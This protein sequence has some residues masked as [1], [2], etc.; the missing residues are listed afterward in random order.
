M[1]AQNF[2][3]V[4]QLG[5]LQVEVLPKIEAQDY[6]VRRNLLEMVS[7]T[8]GLQLHGGVLGQL[9]KNDSSILD[10]LIRRYCDL[11]WEALHKGVIRRYESRQ[12]NLSVLR[13]R[14]NISQQLRHNAV[15][16][17]RLH[18]TFDEFTQDTELNRVLKL[19]LRIL[20][21]TAKSASS[22]RSLSE[23]LFCFDEVADVSPDMV[24]W[25]RVVFDRLSARYQPLIRMAKLFIDGHSPDLTAGRSDGFAVLFDM[26][27][28]FEEYVG[29]Q[30]QRLTAK[31]GIRTMLQQPVMNLA[32]RENGAPCFQMRPDIVVMD[33]V[34]P[35]VV[36]DTKWKRLQPGV[37]KEAVSSQDIYQLY[38]YSQRYKSKH[39]YMVY[40]HHPELGNW[41]PTRSR[42]QFEGEVTGHSD[43]F[44]HITTVKLDDLKT[45]PQQLQAI[46]EQSMVLLNSGGV[47]QVGLLV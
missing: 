27:E 39:V 7:Q 34:N 3:G 32:R 11:L 26:N 23:L 10:V 6:Q 22:T 14:I 40:P 36:L 28:L 46:L 30:V 20:L 47:D 9:E 43:S 24:R 18:C 17:D 31:R 13:G 29:R 21:K 41:H 37:S 42:Y 4:I 38:A 5:T 1:I 44:L 45:V 19:S 35:A 2:V 15:R 8:L 12:E 16:P 33:G 25:D